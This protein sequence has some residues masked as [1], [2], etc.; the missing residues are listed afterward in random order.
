[1]N[2]KQNPISEKDAA[3]LERERII[4]Y[5][6][7]KLAALGYPTS[8][9]LKDSDFLEIA[10]PLLSNH[11]EKN[12]LLSN[13]PCPVDQRVQNFLN[14]YLKDVPDRHDVHLPVSAFSLDH[15]GLARV[16]SLAPDK[17]IF[18]SDIITS[19]RVRQGVLNNPKNDRRTTQGVFHI[20]DGGLPIPDDKITVPKNVFEKLLRAALH[21]PRELMRLPFT[22]NQENQAELFVS[23]LLRPIVCPEVRGFIPEK[24]MEIRFFAPG[25]LISNLDFVESIFGNGGDPY[26]PENDAALDTEHWTGHTGCVILAP[27]LIYLKKKDLGLPS[28]EQATE[29][30]RRDGMC[31]KTDDE[32]YNNGGAFKITCRDERGIMVTLIADNYYGYCKKEVKTQISFSTN[33]FGLSEEEHAGGAI[34]FPSYD[35]GEEFHLDEALAKNDLTFRDIAAR[36]GNMMDLKPEGYG[37]DKSFPSIL[38]IPESATFNLSQQSVTWPLNGKEQKIKLLASQIYVL[39]SGYKIYMKKQTGGPSWHLIGVVA[40]GTLCHKPCTVSGGGKS[41]ISKSIVDAMIQGPVFCPDFHQDIEVITKILSMD[42]SGRFS[43]PTM[44]KRE[45]RLILSPKRSLG[46]VIKLLTPSSEYTETF[47]NWLKSLPH[48]IKEMIFTLKR[49]YKPEWGANWQEHFSVDRVNGYMGHELK[50]RSRKLVA[51]Y[52]RVG[53]EKDGA[54][55]IYKVR[56]DFAAAE[57]IQTEDDISASVVVPVDQLSGLDPEYGNTSVKIVTNC[58]SMLFQRPDDAILRGYDK[59][60]EDDLS[61]P[62]TFLSNYEPLSRKEAE[63]LI[64]DAIHFDL[65]TAPVKKLIRDFLAEGKPDYF[66][67]SAHPRVVDGKPS[68]NPRYLQRRPDLVNPRQKYLAETGVRF[69]RKIPLDKPVF[70]PVNAVLPGRRNNPP[71]AKAGIPALA[72]YNPIHYQELPELFMDFICSLTGKSPSTTGFGSE[73]ALTKGPFNAL[74]PIVDLN[75][76]LVS[77]VVTGYDGF[78]SAAGYLGPNHKVDHDISLLV[79]EIWCRMQP[80]ERDP[81]FLIRNGYLEKLNDFEFRE[82]TVPASILGY[83]ITIRFVRAFLGRIFNNPNAVFSDEML[84]PEEQDLPVYAEGIENIA[85]THKRVA[86]HYFNDGSIQAACPPLKALLTIMKDGTFEGKDRNHPDIRGMFTKSYLLKSAWYQKR[87]ATKQERDIALWER[88][89][90]YL[91]SFLSKENHTEAIG[92]LNL[93]DRLAKA[94]KNLEEARSAGYLKKLHGTIGADPLEAQIPSRAT[95]LTNAKA[96]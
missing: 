9:S 67:S 22:S 20:A 86:E 4:L 15:P 14:D 90:A 96:L 71:D 80:H 88:H 46:S 77:Y 65:Y 37:I 81:Q 49:F 60:A 19:Y 42:F 84:A 35:L 31:W 44:E 24:R 92:Q 87:L 62:D 68:K 63:A 56:Q 45:S 74:W 82:K 70:M 54:W 27:H 93:N 76:A 12:R 57:K 47:N 58:E 66:V 72:V 1:M 40:E 13:H 95:K 8:G 25:N 36:Y 29:R 5:I 75:N 59:Q 73:G 78:T 89:V 52:L 55:R 39:P 83:R 23:L 79:P 34:A 38:Y 64:E 51:N 50:F 32:P 11:K 21:P 41:E 43:D 17:D 30:Q 16:M 61:S 3:A 91:R 10:S 2:P 53:K 7:L 26:L 28:Y 85:A 33:L 48:H 18:N 6:N 94:S 69:A